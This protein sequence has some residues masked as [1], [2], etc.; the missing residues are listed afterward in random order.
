M[1]E[2][3]DARDLWRFHGVPYYEADRIEP[4]V[5]TAVRT[6]HYVAT[7]RINSSPAADAEVVSA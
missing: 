5:V 3:F 6:M 2:T 4:T 1:N 7:L